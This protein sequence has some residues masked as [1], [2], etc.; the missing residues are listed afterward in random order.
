VEPSSLDE[1][2][3]SLA[4]DPSRVS[5]VAAWCD[6]SGHRGMGYTL[7]WAAGRGRWPERRSSYN[8]WW[9]TLGGEQ[10]P[11][12][13]PDTITNWMRH[14]SP[15]LSLT[16]I[17]PNGAGLRVAFEMLEQALELIVLTLNIWSDDAHW[18][19]VAKELKDHFR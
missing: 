3:E 15:F 5:D 17:G 2:F 14:D 13:L 16:A 11:A 8:W 9:D 6:K 1:A 12:Y 19:D 18:V 10:N 4:A 7:R